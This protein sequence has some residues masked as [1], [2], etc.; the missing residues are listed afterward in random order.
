MAVAA[1]RAIPQP[2]NAAIT[3]MLAGHAEDL[4]FG[5]RGMFDHEPRAVQQQLNAMRRSSTTDAIR[6][7]FIRSAAFALACLGV[8]TFLPLRQS[9]K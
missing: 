3:K 4:A 7:A 1:R 8:S 6:R 5:E 9:S 2:S